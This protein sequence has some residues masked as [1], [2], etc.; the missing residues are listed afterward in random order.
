MILKQR[1]KKTQAHAD[2]QLH[3]A[4]SAAR[5]KS[6]VSLTFERLD[7]VREKYGRD[8]GLETEVCRKE[9]CGKFFSVMKWRH[10]ETEVCGKVLFQKVEKAETWN[11]C[12]YSSPIC[13]CLPGSLIRNGPKNHLN[14]ASKNKTL[15]PSAPCR[16]VSDTKNSRVLNILVLNALGRLLP[17][18]PVSLARRSKETKNY[19]ILPLCPDL[20]DA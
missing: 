20:C 12:T 9:V 13:H 18:G 19:N 16:A 2:A 7:L 3:S 14:A 17:L 5:W 10:A 11:N 8:L 1:M 4:V 6:T 15:I